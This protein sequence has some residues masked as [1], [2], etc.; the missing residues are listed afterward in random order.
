MSLNTN[1]AAICR[2]GTATDTPYSLLTDQFGFTG[3]YYHSKLLTGLTNGRSYQYHIR[4]RDSKGIDDDS[5]FII[6]FRI[7][8]YAD[9]GGEGEGTPGPG[10][11]G[12]GGGGGGGMG[13]TTGPGQGELLPFPPPPGAPNITLQGYAH[14]SSEVHMLKDGKEE[15]TSIAGI[16]SKFKFDV[17]SLPQGVYTFSVWAFDQDKRKSVIQAYTVYLKEG[18]QTQVNNIYISPTIQA[19]NQTVDPGKPV[20]AFGF[21]YPGS[22][23]E[24]WLY[25]KKN[26]PVKDSEIIKST[27]TAGSDGFWSA[28]INTTGMA[29]G[30]YKIKARGYTKNLGNSE[31]SQTLDIGLGVSAGISICAGADL[32]KDGKVNLYDFSILLFYWNTNNECA[33]QNKDGKVDLIDFSIMMYYWTG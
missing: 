25:P 27:V 23:V 6:S 26:T 1:Y 28:S 11:G 33:D 20:E 9:Q 14:P 24:V 12:A 21:V 15:K 19:R 29:E 10:G 17:Y 4:C 8:G 32:N 30:Q 5:D 2:Y 18:T 7:P 13:Q 16:D 22:T 31:F 3:G